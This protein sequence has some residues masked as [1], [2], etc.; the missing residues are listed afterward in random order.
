MS[1][2]A[3]EKLAAELGVVLLVSHVLQPRDVAPIESLL[4]GNVH[5]IGIG[6]GAMPMLFPRRDP[7]RVAGADFAQRATPQ[8]NPAHAGDNVQGL[9]QWMGMPSRARFR[10]E[11]APR[12]P[13]PRR[14]RGLDDGLLPHRAGERIGA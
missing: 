9:T 3:C 7:D 14:R 6:T 13:D 10:L 11:A 4:Q 8:L 1:T 12:A 2:A 5:H